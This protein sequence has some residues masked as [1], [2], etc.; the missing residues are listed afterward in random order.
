[1]RLK[2]VEK[3]T[4]AVTKGLLHTQQAT[5]SQV[6]TG[7]LTCRCL[8]LAE[9]ARCFESG[10]A[11]PHNLKRVFR[12]ASN[13]RLT[14][15]SAKELVASRLIRQLH[16]RLKTKPQQYLEVIVDWTSVWPYQVLSAL[17]PLEGRAVPVLQWG[18]EKWAYPASQNR[19]EEQFIGSLR[20]S[21]P[22]RWKV[23]I[24]ADRGFQRV[25]FL[26]CLERH[27]FSFVVRVKGDAWVESGSYG[28][29]LRDYPLSV[30]QC[31]KLSPCTY[32]KTKRY[33]LKLALTCAQID[34]KVSSWLLATDLGMTARQIVALYRRRFWCEESFRDQKQEFALEQVRVKQAGRLENLLLALSIALLILAVIGMRGKKLGYGDKFAA[35]N[36]KQTVLSW[37]Q[38][39][40][41]L[42]RASTRY[43]NLLFDNQAGCFSFRWA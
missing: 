3:F 9:I 14:A 16:H 17:V 6:V 37:V 18:V 36:K 38:V 23:V 39:A 13:E 1:M 24:L 40:L 33:P 4:K 7:L 43:L 21:I 32:H 27:G 12:F 25:D 19:Y 31:F 15:R 42:L 41:H 10:V 5:L 26:R 29:P 20:R 35:P 8:I 22:K 28:G 34:G 30:G 2:R 11:F